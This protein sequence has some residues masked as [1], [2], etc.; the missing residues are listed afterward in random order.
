M[1]TSPTG[2][3][4][5]NGA[6]YVPERE[7]LPLLAYAEMVWRR[8]LLVLVVA[9][10][11]AVPA[12][13]VSSLET[14]L[15]QATAQILVTQRTL[16]QSFNIGDQG[17]SDLQI[18][19]QVAILTSAAVAARAG[20]LGATSLVRGSGT[21][22]SNVITLTTLEPDPVAAAGSIRAFLTAYSDYRSSQ[23]NNSLDAAAGKIRER[24]QALEGS[25]DQL[26]GLPAQVLQQQVAIQ[27][28]QLRLQQ[29]LGQLEVQRAL[30]AAGSTVVKEPQVPTAPTSP[31]PLRNGALGLVLGLVLGISLAVVLETLRRRSR[32]STATEAVSSREAGSETTRL[33]APPMA[34]RPSAVAPG[35]RSASPFR[36]EE[37]VAARRNGGLPSWAAADAQP[38]HRTTTSGSTGNH[39]AGPEQPL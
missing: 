20:E 5:P 32:P 23:L 16:D 39:Q 7:V 21:K 36:P 37:S 35:G 14:P 1:M 29:Q 33:E 15:Y 26:Q 30:A 13:V 8:R 12:Y 19:T 34:Q 22:G 6:S 25:A 3:H 38:V 27:Q 9:L 4:S 28:E 17:L 10:G 2:L 18:N 31:Q 24:L 11:M